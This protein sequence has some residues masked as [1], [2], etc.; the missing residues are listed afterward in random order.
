MPP[1]PPPLKPHLDDKLSP[2]AICVGPTRIS[3]V[4]I[5]VRNTLQGRKA[6]PLTAAWCLIMLPRIR[7]RALNG[8]PRNEGMVSSV[9]APSVDPAE[10]PRIVAAAAQI[11]ESAPSAEVK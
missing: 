5:W 1:T 3:F 4:R 11:Y 2:L 7:C 10:Q 9:E 6:S 8:Q